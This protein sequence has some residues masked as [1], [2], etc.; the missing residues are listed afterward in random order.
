MV[1]RDAFVQTM[2]DY[3]VTVGHFGYHGHLV[4]DHH[5]RC[6]VFYLRDDVVEMSL[7]LFVYIAQRLIKHK[8]FGTRYDGP[9]EQRPLQLTA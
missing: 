4:R 2:V 9:A 5:Y 8:Q 3:Q 7:K 1:M 6:L